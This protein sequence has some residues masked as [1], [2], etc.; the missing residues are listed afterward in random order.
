MRYLVR[1]DISEALK[2]WDLAPTDLELD[3]T[4]SMLAQVTWTQNNMLERLRQ[5]GVRIAL[6][7]FGGEYSSF[8]YVRKYQIDHLKIAQPLVDRAMQEPDRAAAIS[9][10]M[11]LGRA[12]G[13]GVIAAGVETEEQ[14]VLLS[15]MGSHSEAQGFY[16]SEPVPADR[17]LALLR[18]GKLRP[19]ETETLTAA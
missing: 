19:T 1:N 2:K 12:L 16:F 17:A 13:I 6:D 14:R 10:I 8:D 3:V 15:S 9:A 4:E 5:L 11:G 7:D 18:Q